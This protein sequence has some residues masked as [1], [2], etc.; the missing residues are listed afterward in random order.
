MELTTTATVA[1]LGGNNQRFAIGQP[2]ELICVTSAPSLID[3]LEWTKQDSPLNLNSVES[4]E[5][6]VLKFQNFQVTFFIIF[7]AEN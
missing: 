5:A 2:A 7:T 4:D 6:G 3:R 1:I